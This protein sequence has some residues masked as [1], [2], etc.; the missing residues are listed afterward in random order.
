MGSQSRAP[1]IK[2]PNSLS[3]HNSEKGKKRENN[4]Q[5]QITE[6][7]TQWRTWDTFPK[8]PHSHYHRKTGRREQ[9]GETGTQREPAQ[10]SRFQKGA[11]RIP[12]TVTVHKTDIIFSPRIFNVEVDNAGLA[13][14]DG[15]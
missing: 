14:Y 1:K 8:T 4:S 7:V 11:G 15:F 12:K 9:A 2:F 3:H 5:E 10:E 13:Y 6:H